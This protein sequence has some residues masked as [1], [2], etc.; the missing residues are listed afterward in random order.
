MDRTSIRKVH[1]IPLSPGPHLLQLDVLRTREKR[2]TRVERE[3]VLDQGD[4]LLVTCDPVQPNVFYRRSPVADTW[5]LQIIRYGIVAEG[6]RA[7][8]R[9]KHPLLVLVLLAAGIVAVRQ[10]AQ[11]VGGIWEDVIPP[12]FAMGMAGIIGNYLRKRPGP[13]RGLGEESD[14]RDG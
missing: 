11:E 10:G 9:I 6:V 3:V 7:M 2:S 12:A 1:F 4:V 13:T 5:S 14:A 8:R